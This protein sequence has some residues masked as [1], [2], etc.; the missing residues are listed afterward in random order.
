MVFV[1]HPVHAMGQFKFRRN[2]NRIFISTIPLTALPLLIVSCGD[3]GYSG[4]PPVNHAGTS[5][6]ALGS[7]NMNCGTGPGGTTA[8]Q[9]TQKQ[10]QFQP[11]QQQSCS[12]KFQFSR[13]KTYN[14]DMNLDCANAVV[15]IATTSGVQTQPVQIPVQADGTVQG[16]GTF[17]EQVQGDTSGENPTNQVCWVQFDATFS[18]KATCP[19]NSGPITGTGNGNASS[20]AQRKSLTVT[21]QVN[22]TQAD[23]TL[24]QQAGV[25]GPFESPG[26]K[27]GSSVSVTPLPSGLPFGLPLPLAS[28][29]P[30][31]CPSGSPSASATGT[32]QVICRVQN[33]CPIAASTDL[34][35][36]NQQQAQSPPLAS[37]S[38]GPST[39]PFPLPSLGPTLGQ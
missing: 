15:N 27:P 11:T 23:P 7:V 14:F 36:G 24:L 2:Q 4:P 10:V 26:S 20:S 19:A 1:L 25:T 29:P 12:Q 28:T 3:G 37:P 6:V 17:I 34:S 21:T 38:A 9:Q 31:A 32:A 18:G 22:F 13:A 30:S 35:C 39:S 33:P 16:H 5:P 8:Q